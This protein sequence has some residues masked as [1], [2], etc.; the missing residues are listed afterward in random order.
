MDVLIKLDLSGEN[1]D[2]TWLEY[3]IFYLLFLIRILD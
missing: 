2:Q 1:I 3:E